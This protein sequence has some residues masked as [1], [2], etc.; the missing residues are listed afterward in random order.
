MSPA[1][2]KG[3]LRETFTKIGVAYARDVKELLLNTM[4]QRFLFDRRSGADRRRGAEQR[5]NP[6]LDLPHK[7][8]RKTDDR[9]QQDRSMSDDF[10]ASN[11]FFIQA[12]QPRP[13]TKH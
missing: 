8:R 9:R 5:K 12:K 2:L 13:R 7:R 6:R 3:D 10:Y 1:N 4:S 11:N